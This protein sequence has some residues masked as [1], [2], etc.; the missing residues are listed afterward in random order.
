M[1]K[2]YEGGEPRQDADEID[3]EIDE[4]ANLPAA[5]DDDEE[6]E[7][8]AQPGDGGFSAYTAEDLENAQWLGYNLADLKFQMLTR[9]KG[10]SPPTPSELREAVARE[11]AQYAA[12][13]ERERL[14]SLKPKTEYFSPTPEAR[15][16]LELAGQAWPSA[17]PLHSPELASAR[18]GGKDERTVEHRMT[19][20][21]RDASNV[22]IVEDDRAKFLHA[23]LATRACTANGLR[24]AFWASLMSNM[25]CS[26]KRFLRS[27]R[28]PSFARSPALMSAC[29][30]CSKPFASAGRN[31]V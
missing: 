31:R 17:Q 11:K 28:C 25:P 14:D 27:A 10:F 18:D 24:F 12:K 20:Y 3:D 23:S 2:I 26:A 9:P 15:A 5:E 19:A 30:L 8:E 16:A 6:D 29:R 21:P 7:A 22:I 1:A 13:L 4:E